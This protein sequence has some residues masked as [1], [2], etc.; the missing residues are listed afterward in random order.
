MDFSVRMRFLQKRGW[1]TVALLMF[2]LLAVSASAESAEV[3]LTG[4]NGHVLLLKMSSKVWSPVEDAISLKPGDTVQT[5][6]ESTA[7]VSFGKD[8]F[9]KLLPMTILT[10]REA[11]SED[12]AP[13]RVIVLSQGKTWAQ[14]AAKDKEGPFVLITPN[15][16]G[17]GRKANAFF[18][19]SRSNDES[20]IDLFQGEITL[21]SRDKPDNSVDMKA[22]QRAGVKNKDIIK[23]SRGFTDFFDPSQS[24]RS[25][26]L[27][28][29][30]SPETSGQIQKNDIPGQE[31]A[32]N[33]G[34]IGKPPSE[35][36]HPQT[37]AES[38]QTAPDENT[39]E[40]QES[41]TQSGSV[42][43][44][45]VAA[46]TPDSA[47]SSPTPQAAEQSQAGSSASSSPAPE[48][49][50]G[51][52]IEIVLTAS[53]TMSTSKPTATSGAASSATQTTAITTASAASPPAET[54]SARSEC[55]GS[56]TISNVYLGTE[57][58]SN[59]GDAAT[60]KSASKCGVY[61]KPTLRWTA[62]AKCGQIKSQKVVINGMAATVATPTP[63]ATVEGKYV[64]E[65]TD[66][67]AREINIRIQDDGEES[68]FALTATVPEPDESVLPRITQLTVNGT[69]I[70]TGT[71]TNVYAD[72]CEALNIQLEG[73]AKSDCGEVTMVEMK[74]FEA[75]VTVYGTTE[76]SATIVGKESA[77]IPVSILV[78]D[79]TGARSLPFKFNIDFMK[80][81]SNPQVSIDT[82]VNM[83]APGLGEELDVYR[84]ELIEGYLVVQG[85]AG[86]DQCL[87]KKVEVTA[88]GGG[89]WV[90]SGSSNNWA[91]KFRPTDG[92]YEIMARATDMDGNQSD[93]MFQAV[94][95]N[96]FS[97]TLE[98][99]LRETFDRM[100]QAYQDKDSDG[101]LEDT[102][103]TYSSR[104]DS[105]EDKN[106][107][108]SAL[109]GRFTSPGQV[110][111]RTRVANTMISG[112]SG[113]VT[114]DWE[115]RPGVSGY[116]K[117]GTFVFQRERRGWK[118]I[119]V[120]DDKTF[121][122]YTDKV[123]AIDLQSSKSTLI[124]DNLDSTQIKISVRDSADN[125]IKDGTAVRLTASTGT[126]DS[127]VTT[128]GGT[129]EVTYTASDV[130]G[131]ATV[132]A[133]SGGVSKSFSLTLKREDAPPPPVVAH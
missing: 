11:E 114:F 20:C 28:S 7:I 40:T 3:K 120:E 71:L 59:S 84:N 9:V 96:Y 121:L 78:R 108:D 52:E 39:G 101:F 80:S 109:S 49:E 72:N 124:A 54:P 24:Q 58:V 106:R 99:I 63:A 74:A 42:P 22:N 92:T 57:A 117:T 10:V 112:T 125:P 60:I 61:A 122:R 123:A 29:A 128:Y 2:S 31:I 15:A 126:I 56:P 102:G 65:I 95:V 27:Q 94:I 110:S 64:F 115:T 51:E 6:R 44:D 103:S 1:P 48:E 118:F 98:E 82:I 116:S 62:T 17:S 69:I 85:T 34:E 8:S 32:A 5:E 36:S 67:T 87:L 18:E 37:P 131:T 50:E 113:R 16:V 88:D 35:I 70:K 133:D 73:T 129:A 68:V 76:W 81:I 41:T 33:P 90:S 100:I 12:G 130:I 23:P 97:K 46:F 14:L 111:L 93:E 107:L 86:S 119:T 38:E 89:T 53:V 21:S 79:V 43:I 55:S 19:S 75:P 47:P 30:A 45:E 83:E 91:Y 13:S 104:H 127:S 4:I 66:S 132:T 105:I 77:N 25:C 26:T